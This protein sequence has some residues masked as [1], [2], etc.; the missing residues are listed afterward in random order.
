MRA[1]SMGTLVSAAVC[2][3]ALLGCGGGGGGGSGGGSSDVA[4]FGGAWYFTRTD[5]TSACGNS[6]KLGVPITIAQAGADLTLTSNQ[7]SFAGSVSGDIAS[8]PGPLIVFHVDTSQYVRYTSVS[9]Q[10]NGTALEG[11]AEVSVSASPSG[12]P[13][14]CQGDA[15]ILIVPEMRLESFNLAGAT[16][17]ALDAPL[18]FR[19]TDDVDPASVTPDSLQILGT[20]PFFWATPV[21]VDGR[22]LALLP[23]LPNFADYS[24]AGL[25]PGADYDL[26]LPDLLSTDT[27]RS[28]RGA[29][30]A[31]RALHTFR[32]V[33]SV[34]F[35]EPRRPLVHSPGPLAS[36]L[37][38]GDEDGCL[39]NPGNGLF[40]F[41]GFQAGATA[42]DT[43][44]CLLNEG[45]PHVIPELCDPAH[46][47]RNVG[48]PSAASPGQ[49]DLPA[50]RIRLNEP[51]DPADVVLRDA[52]TLR[53]VNVQLWR[54]GDAAGSPIA[55]DASNQMQV[56]D[57]LVVQ[58]Y[59]QT[60]VILVAS[61]AVP[62]GTYLVNVR[63]LTDLAGNPL[64]T[65]DAPSPSIGGYQ[66]IEA[67][68]AGVVP[69]GYRLYFRTP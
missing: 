48:T 19:F 17:V 45:P 62:P 49:V 8:F 29:P 31:Q 54:V 46:D 59:L 23:Y 44:L 65:S 18:I 11:T 2:L 64:V 33:P 56:N 38:R 67:A 58:D 40:S 35:V 16:D 36:P 53:S 26:V 42:S 55:V 27:I 63:G 50:L 47:A 66:G 1:R 10:R 60:E 4:S 3:S 68:V 51:V 12:T 6:P 21:V 39:N 52:G 61:N 34:V 20:A 28:T 43:L 30:L 13:A 9:V 24:D 7:G 32:T 14:T 37:G 69:P 15:A 22:E 25:S 41:P 5:P 57:P